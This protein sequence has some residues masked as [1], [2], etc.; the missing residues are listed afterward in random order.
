M[1]LWLA[2][3]ALW[4]PPPISFIQDT[5]IQ[6]AG[7]WL[8]RKT[9]APLQTRGLQCQYYRSPLTPVSSC[10]ILCLQGS[11]CSKRIPFLQVSLLHSRPMLTNGHSNLLPLQLNAASPGCQALSHCAPSLGVWVTICPS[12]RWHVTLDSPSTPASTSNQPTCCL[13]HLLNA[14]R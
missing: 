2:L 6:W 12:P 13:F 10:P 9:T 11:T 5:G 8:G 14:P 4:L 7:V 1:S 3:S